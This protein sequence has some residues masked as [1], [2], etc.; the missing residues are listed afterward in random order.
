[1]RIEINK[2]LYIIHTISE[3]ANDVYFITFGNNKTGYV[4]RKEII[5]PAFTTLSI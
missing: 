5:I 4:S 2:V 3:V 1:M